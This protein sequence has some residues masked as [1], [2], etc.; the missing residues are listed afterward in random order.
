MS[1]EQFSVRELQILAKSGKKRSE[2]LHMR[3]YHLDWALT[4]S[5][6]I[7]FELISPSHRQP[8]DFAKG[9]RIFDLAKSALDNDCYR[10]VAVIQT[11]NL[12]Y[13][14]S[15]TQHFDT[16]WNE[17]PAPGIEPIGRGP[18][19]SSAV[20]DLIEVDGGAFHFVHSIGFKVL[21]GLVRGS[22]S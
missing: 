4:G 20:G 21:P 9:G 18:F 3:V 19:R 2:D 1:S 14:W 8:V 16:K 6:N 5:R 13:A 10:L 17:A 7:L 12:D 11:N 15:N 22:H